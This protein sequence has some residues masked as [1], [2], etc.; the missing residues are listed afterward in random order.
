[1]AKFASNMNAKLGY[2]A[3]TV[4][5]TTPATPSLQNQPFD[6]FTLSVSAAELVDPRKTGSREL[7]AV[8]PGNNTYSGTLTGPL[9]YSNYD[10]L[11]AGFMFNDWAT[12][13][14]KFGQSRKSFTMEVDQQDATGRYIS[15]TGVLV[16]GFTLDSP[17]GDS[18]TTV[19]FDLTA[20]GIDTDATTSLDADGYTAVT[21]YDGFKSCGGTVREGGTVIANVQTINLTATNNLNPLQ[22]W[23]ECEP[24]DVSEGQIDV[25]GTLTLFYSDFYVLNKFLAG[26]YSSLEFTLIDGAGNQMKFYLPRIKYNGGD[27]PVDSGSGE[28]LMSL[29]F[30]A[31]KDATAGSGLVIT[32]IAA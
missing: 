26:S 1:M 13:V 16:N 7:S 22:A 9:S 20:M 19:Q 29:P 23:G 8:I 6:S 21:M 25:T 28:R 15:Y 17:A 27:A 10:H 2:V 3:E 12:N 31:V 30:R 4:F 11:F 18:L 5:N 24:S 14:L 32:R